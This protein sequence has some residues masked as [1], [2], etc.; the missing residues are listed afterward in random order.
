MVKEFK[1]SMIYYI[2][3]LDFVFASKVIFYLTAPI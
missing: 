2:L 3:K 1:D